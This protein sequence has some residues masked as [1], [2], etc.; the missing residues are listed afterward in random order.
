M[1]YKIIFGTL[2][3]SSVLMA[4]NLTKASSSD[5]KNMKTSMMEQAQMMPDG[6]KH[7]MS[8]MSVMEVKEKLLKLLSQ[9]NIKFFTTFEHSALA[10]EAGLEL[11]DTVV[12]VYG[13]PK[14]GTLLMQK[15]NEIALELPLKVL[16]YA[17]DNATHIAYKDIKTIATPFNLQNDPV[18]DKI[19]K[20]QDALAKEIAN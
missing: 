13:S 8:K 2:L 11:P 6:L 12:V 15:S 16:I 14:V 10:K 18:V 17:K 5:I 19:S 1:K 20:L 9:K 4:D 7:M 3:L